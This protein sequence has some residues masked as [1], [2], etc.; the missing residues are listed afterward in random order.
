LFFTLTAAWYVNSAAHLFGTRP[1][2]TPDNSRNNRF[3]TMMAVIGEGWHNNH[4]AFPRSANFGLQP[5]EFDIGYAFIRLL[6][7]LGC[8]DR[9]LVA[10]GQQVSWPEAE[11]L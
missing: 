6:E 1:F 7:R 2:A 8:V 5:G 4:H 9:V 10:S 3:V 11:A